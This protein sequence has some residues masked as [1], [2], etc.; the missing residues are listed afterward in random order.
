[1]V[2]NVAKPKGLKYLIC[3]GWG[4]RIRDMKGGSGDRNLTQ[5]AKAYPAGVTCEGHL[6][7]ITLF[8]GTPYSPLPKM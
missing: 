5:I 8:L 2:T 4:E 1:M 7:D 3:E 6:A